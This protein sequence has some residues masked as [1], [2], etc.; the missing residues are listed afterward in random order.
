MLSPARRR[1]YP[2]IS[3]FAL[4][5]QIQKYTLFHDGGPYNIETSL[6]VSKANQWTGF[7]MTATSVIKELVIYD[8]VLFLKT[9]KVG[10]SP[11]KKLLLCA[12]MKSL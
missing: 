7:Y 1:V 11:S 5:T 2:T 6:L 12:L 3:T 4:L 10:L 8:E 9:F